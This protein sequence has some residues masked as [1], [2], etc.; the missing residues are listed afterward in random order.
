MGLLQ[1]RVGDEHKTGP[2]STRGVALGPRIQDP[3]GTRVIEQA[4]RS[5]AKAPSGLTALQA[6]MLEGVGRPFNKMGRPFALPS[7]DRKC[8][9]NSLCTRVDTVREQ[10]PQTEEVEPQFRGGGAPLHLRYG[11]PSHHLRVHG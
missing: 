4:L 1:V 2:I 5:E 3:L 8:V 10:E 7:G 11:N 6:G 9:M